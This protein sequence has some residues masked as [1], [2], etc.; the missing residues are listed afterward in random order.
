MT[1]T[2]PAPL[3]CPILV[4]RI[5][6]AQ[7]TGDTLAEAMRDDLLTRFSRA[8]ARHV[9][10]D[11]RPVDY[12][13]SAGFRPLLSLLK[14]VRAKGGRMV[15]CGLSPEIEEIFRHTRL[16]STSGATP[17]PFEVQPDV[18][19]AVAELDRPVPQSPAPP[20]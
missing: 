17:A 14:E 4:L 6:A 9:V 15:L 12:L 7:F 20:A 16:I 8:G 2:P 18:A 13:S 10:V 5:E 11:F 3:T 19:A 1:P